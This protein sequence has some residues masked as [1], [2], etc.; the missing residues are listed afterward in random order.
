MKEALHTMS[1]KEI[2]RLEVIQKTKGKQLTV[3]AL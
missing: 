1:S 3:S 2:D